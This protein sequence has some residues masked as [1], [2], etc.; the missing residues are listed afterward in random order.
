MKLD[1]SEFI[2]LICE[3]FSAKILNLNLYSSAEAYDL[4]NF[5]IYSMNLNSVYVIEVTAVMPVKMTVAKVL[6]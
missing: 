2:L 6:I 1:C 4:P 3:S 5:E